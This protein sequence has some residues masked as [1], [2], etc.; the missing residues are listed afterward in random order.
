MKIGLEKIDTFDKYTFE[1]K[2]IPATTAD[3]KT[4]MYAIWDTPGSSINRR[5]TINLD[6]DEATLNFVKIDVEIP[7][8]QVSNCSTSDDDFDRKSWIGEKQYKSFCSQ[9]CFDFII[10]YFDEFCSF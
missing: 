8:N 4:K 7:V 3:A 9:V 2:R 6:I 10:H 5:T 1:Y